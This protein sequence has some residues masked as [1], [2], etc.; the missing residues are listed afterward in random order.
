MFC[1]ITGYVTGVLQIASGIV[2]VKSVVSVVRFFKENNASS[3]INTG[4]LCQ[5]A[6]AF[7]LYLFTSTA[8][9]FTWAIFTM[10]DSV[11][12]FKMF[13]ISLFCYKVGSFIA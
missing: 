13:L 11:Q 3:Y 12:I 8:Y 10:H 7:G 1:N 4:M 9:Y 5:H 2:L 6:A